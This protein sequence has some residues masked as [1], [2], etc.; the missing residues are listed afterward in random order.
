MGNAFL[1]YV[2]GKMWLLVTLHYCGNNRLKGK[3]GYLFIMFGGS[4]L[5]RGCHNCGDLV[6]EIRW[7]MGLGVSALRAMGTRAHILG[8]SP[9]PAHH[10]AAG[11]YASPLPSPGLSFL[12]CELSLLQPQHACNSMERHNT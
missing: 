5:C 1:C 7:Q 3:P 2:S 8:S 6:D 12:M 10:E 11:P 9:S 4:R